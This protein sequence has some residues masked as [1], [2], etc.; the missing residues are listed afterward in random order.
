VL[1]ALLYRQS[2]V[3]VKR[4]LLGG[5]ISLVIVQNALFMFSIDE[6]LSRRCWKRT[7]AG[8]N[9]ICLMWDPSTAP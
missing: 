5:L 1:L 8:D 2:R 9:K 4:L 6:L 7:K 3:P